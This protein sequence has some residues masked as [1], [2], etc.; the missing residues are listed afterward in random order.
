MTCIKNSKYKHSNNRCSVVIFDLDGTL[1]KLDK[2]KDECN[3][4]HDKD[5]DNVLSNGLGKDIIK[6]LELCKLKKIKIALASLNSYA[7]SYLK[8]Y[9]IYDYFDCIQKKTWRLH[10]TDKTDLFYNISEI[11]DTPFENMLFFDDYIKHIIE[12][13]I[14]DIKTITVNDS[15]LLTM[16]N[17]RDGLKLFKNK[18][19]KTYKNL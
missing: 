5:N 16:K 11:F 7:D 17:F 1:H 2:D 6:I 12:A 14:L 3:N 9:G 8:L 18:T 13:K 4:K 19:Y 15:E 10:G